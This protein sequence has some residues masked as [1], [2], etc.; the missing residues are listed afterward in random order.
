MAF[1]HTRIVIH[2]RSLL[3]VVITFFDPLIPITLILL[4]VWPAF[5]PL[6]SAFQI[7]YGEYFP[8]SYTVVRNMKNLSHA[9]FDK[10]WVLTRSKF[11]GLQSVNYG[12]RFWNQCHQL[13]PGVP[14]RK[15]VILSLQ[16]C[17]TLPLR[18]VKEA[19]W[20]TFCLISYHSTNCFSSFDVRNLPLTRVK[21]AQWATFCLISYYSTNCFSSSDVRIVSGPLIF[22]FTFPLCYA[23]ILDLGMLWCREASLSF[24]LPLWMS[25]NATLID[26]SVHNSRL[27]T[28]LAGFTDDF[29]G[30]L[31]GLV[32]KCSCD[33]LHG[34][35]CLLVLPHCKILQNFQFWTW[36]MQIHIEYGYI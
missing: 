33:V 7:R 9:S 1:T 18:R 35:L 36:A 29:C 8:S 24:I 4:F 32:S 12:C 5:K 34:Q 27:F 14:S 22:D 28:C 3:L 20:A 19:Q 25:N 30:G 17:F 6:S 16:I 31:D 15:G 11:S 10:P 23:R 2:S 26:F 21:E 13:L